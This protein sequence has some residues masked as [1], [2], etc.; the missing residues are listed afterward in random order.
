MIQY[1]PSKDAKS[2]IK[3][4]M[5]VVPL[6]GIYYKY[7]SLSRKRF[8]STPAGTTQGSHVGMPLL[9]AAG[10]LNKM[11]QAVRD[12]F[13]TS[14]DLVKRLLV[15]H[16]F[17]TG[18]MRQNGQMPVS[19]KTPALRERQS[20]FVRQGHILLHV[21]AYKE[22]RIRKPVRILSSNHFADFDDNGKPI[23]L[24]FYNK[25]MGVDLA[26]MLKTFYSDNKKVLKFGRR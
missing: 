7:E 24:D 13:F 23:I 9:E 6:L 5:L 22:V 8:D 20:V 19:I 4:W 16:T 3:I 14:I 12:N 15:R 21:Y 2:V 11:Y 25:H 26:D 10:L 17:M 18:T 1:I